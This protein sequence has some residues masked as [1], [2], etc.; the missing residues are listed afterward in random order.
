VRSPH[1]SDFVVNYV[2]RT[3]SRTARQDAGVP[4]EQFAP[5]LVIQR[6]SKL[7]FIVKGRLWKY[8]SHLLLCQERRNTRV[9]TGLE[10][11]FGALEK[12]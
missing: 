10:P 7:R 5:G 11:D 9:C 4:E 8:F 1:L 2:P 12:F 6:T 3:I